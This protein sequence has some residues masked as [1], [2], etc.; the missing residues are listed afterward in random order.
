MLEIALTPEILG[1]P[2]IMGPRLKPF[3]LMVN[4]R[5][6]RDNGD[7]QIQNIFIPWLLH[8]VPVL[9]TLVLKS[10]DLPKFYQSHNVAMF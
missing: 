4:P 3:S 5:L 8:F 1:P 6:C 7:Q 9:N 10:S 2:E